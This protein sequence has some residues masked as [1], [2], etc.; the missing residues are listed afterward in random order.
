VLCS[1]AKSEV[2]SLVFVLN[3]W[4]GSLSCHWFTRG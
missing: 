4:F 3:F 1:F 2:S